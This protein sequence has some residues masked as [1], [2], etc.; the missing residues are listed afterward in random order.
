MTHDGSPD[1]SPAPLSAEDR[2]DIMDAVG[3]IMLHVDV[4]DWEKVRSYLMPEVSMDHTSVF[5]GDPVT[6]DSDAFVQG[7]RS[8]LPGFDATQHTVTQICV[9]GG[10]DHAVT[11]SNLR[12]AHWIESDIWAFGGAYRHTLTRTAE[13]WR[14][15]SLAIE[16]HY[17][18][19]DR[20]VRT[21]AVE[22]M[23][24]RLGMSVEE[25]TVIGRSQTQANT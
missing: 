14:I 9:S 10:G 12:A 18:E 20:A 5:G 1:D 22:R 25:L 7:L 15:A 19:G 11:I 4:K 24:A 6:C 23:S 13:G 3:G 17:E 2:L 21:A 8:R 16:M